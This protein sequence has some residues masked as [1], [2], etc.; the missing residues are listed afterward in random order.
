MKRKQ[1]LLAAA[2]IVAAAG[3]ALGTSS[4]AWFVAQKSATISAGTFGAV[5]SEGPIDVTLVSTDVATFD[6][7]TQTVTPKTDYE[8]ITDISGYG[9]GT[10]YKAYNYTSD[11]SNAKVKT[12]SP[13][14]GNWFTFVLNVA[15]NS[16][17]RDINLYLG[18]S[19]DI[20]P[21]NAATAIDVGASK[22]ARVSVI[23]AH[24]GDVGRVYGRMDDATNN[25][26]TNFYHAES[27]TTIPV[28]TFSDKIYS[29]IAA[30]TSNAYTWNSSFTTTESNEGSANDKLG[31]IT[32][33]S[34]INLTVT[35]WLEGNDSE[36]TIE[37]ALD[38]QYKFVLNLIGIEVA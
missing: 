10:F 2:T 27:A 20:A 18:S 33:G 30:F 17:I 29:G 28:S 3:V 36:C 13:M 6:S 37:K 23:G 31:T 1:L 8:K 5:S 19:C 26:A 24:T 12:I 7:L 25:A 16:T 9:N 22:A 34:S 15:N 14:K 35:T 11:G 32:H 21:N 4:Y 38:G